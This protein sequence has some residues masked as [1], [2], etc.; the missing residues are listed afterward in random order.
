MEIVLSH[1]CNLMNLKNVAAY[2]GCDYDRLGAHYDELIGDTRFLDEINACIRRTR[3]VHGITKAIF[4]KEAL[5]SVDWFAFERI[6]IYV[7]IRHFQPGSVLETGVFYGGNTAFAL[8]ALLRNQ[9]GRLISIDYPAAAITDDSQRHSQVGQSEHYREDLKPGFIIPDYLKCNW[10]LIIGDSL[11]VIPTLNE[12]FDF[13]IHDSDHAHDFVCYEI[14]LVWKKKADDLFMVVD[15]I[16]WSNGFFSFCC[17][18]KMHPF[19]FTDN[20]K[21]NLR[22][23][24]GC[25][26]SGHPKNLDPSFVGR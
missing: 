9:K 18:Q 8:L 7:L 6:L 17:A 24:G 11:K 12:R 25:A 10:N 22:V 4:A 15:D 1:E 20:G 23:R 13:Y 21:D 2:L 5:D 19:L 16:D 3:D 26:W 14:D